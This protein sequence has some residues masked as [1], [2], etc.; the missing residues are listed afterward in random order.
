MNI[1]KHFKVKSGARWAIATA[2]FLIAVPPVVAP[3]LPSW[4][5]A[6]SELEGDAEI[7][8]RCGPEYQI[9]LSRW[10]YVYKF[11][12]SSS[13]ARYQGTASGESCRAKFIVEIQGESGEWKI[14]SLVFKD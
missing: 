9:T 3:W 10:F 11:V 12:G 1:R 14:R 7:V 2:V 5:A 13:S 4:D 8:S 6:L